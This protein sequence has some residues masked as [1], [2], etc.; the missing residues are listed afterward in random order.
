MVARTAP[1]RGNGFYL[2]P[3]RYARLLVTVKVI[4]W[5]FFQW[6]KEL[7]SVTTVFWSTQVQIGLGGCRDVL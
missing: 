6:P 4:L 7:D 1:N 2:Q 3:L 5:N